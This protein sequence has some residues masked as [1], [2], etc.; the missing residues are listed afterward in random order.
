M[1]L[2]LVF[3]PGCDLQPRARCAEEPDSERVPRAARALL[4]A[5]PV[6]QARHRPLRP[7]RA[8]RPTLETRMDD[9]RAVLDAVGSER[10]ALFGTSEGGVAC[11]C[12]SPRHIPERTTGARALRHRSQDASGP[13]STRGRTRR[14][15]GA[16]ND[17]RSSSAHWG[18]R[19]HRHLDRHMAPTRTDDV[20]FKRAVLG[21]RPLQR[22][23]GRGRGAPAHGDARSTCGDVLPAIRV[24]TLVARTMTG[25]DRGGGP[26]E[27]AG[28]IPGARV[29]RAAAAPDHL[30][31]ASRPTA[32]S[33][34]SRSS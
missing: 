30:R 5:D 13:P 33:T 26:R 6:R 11:A 25:P 29:R 18:R 10:A 3:V 2:D 19:V 4:A 8:R 27:I 7:R 28:R 22:E 1:P 31:R 34:R 32:R 21:T 20:A 12:S 9:V 23:P 24:P 14:R 15:R 16:R 17:R